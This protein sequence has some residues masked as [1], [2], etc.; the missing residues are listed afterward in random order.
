MKVK[1]LPEHVNLYKYLYA[2]DLY[3]G[4]YFISIEA[5]QWIIFLCIEYMY[6]FIIYYYALCL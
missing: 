4:L 2:W 3:N 1:I 6:L 5:L